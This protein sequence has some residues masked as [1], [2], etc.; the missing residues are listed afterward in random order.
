MQFLDLDDLHWPASNALLSHASAALKARV[1]R[2]EA[3]LREMLGRWVS[4]SE[5]CI[6]VRLG[7][8]EII[9]LARADDP[10]GTIVLT[11]E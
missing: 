4:E 5:P 7:T 6:A 10:T 1:S 9:G 3:T 8:G 2:D 11:P